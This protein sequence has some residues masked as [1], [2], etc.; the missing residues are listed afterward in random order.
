[1][2]IANPFPISPIFSIVVAF[3]EISLTLTPCSSKE[4]ILLNT[5]DNSS[6][7]DWNNSTVEGRIPSLSIYLTEDNKID[8]LIEGKNKKQNFAIIIE[9][10][11]FATDSNHPDRGQ[12]EGYHRYITGNKSDKPRDKTYENNQKTAKNLCRSEKRF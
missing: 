9:N 1:M 8:I 4:A 5:Y 10:K 12:L 3:T 7:L 2:A 6:L 11:I